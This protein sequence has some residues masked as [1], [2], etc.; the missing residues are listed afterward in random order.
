MVRDRYIGSGRPIEGGFLATNKQDF[1]AHVTGGDFRHTADQIDPLTEQIPT[2]RD[3]EDWAKTGQILVVRRGDT[4]GGVLIFEITGVA[5]VLRYWF[6]N[7][8]ATNQGIGS[9]LIRT[10]FHLCRNCR[11]I[12]LWVIAN[13]KD[14]IRKYDHYGFSCD[15]MLDHI[16]V[17]QSQPHSGRFNVENST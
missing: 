15:N 7:Q 10:F 6:V 1:N 3:L 2:I 13:N 14:S 9:K 5:A 8:E 4:L 11:R 17:R 12:S 16:L